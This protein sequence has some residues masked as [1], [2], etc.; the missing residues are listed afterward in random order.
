MD[1]NDI[2]RI[3]PN[4][5]LRH[6]IFNFDDTYNNFFEDS[7]KCI[8]YFSNI[9]A[10][11]S[12]IVFN[13]FS[14]WKQK[15]WRTIDPSNFSGS[16]NRLYNMMNRTYDPLK[17]NR[18]YIDNLMVNISID[19]L[20]D[21]A[22][23]QS[24]VEKIGVD[25]LFNFPIKNNLLT[26]YIYVLKRQRISSRYDSS[27]E[28][29]FSE[30]FNVLK[31][32][33]FITDFNTEVEFIQDDNFEDISW[34]KI[35][36]P[37]IIDNDV[38]LNYS[39]FIRRKNFFYLE[40]TDIE[41]PRTFE[42]DKEKEQIVCLNYLSFN[43]KYSYKILL[44]D[45]SEFKNPSFDKIIYGDTIVEEY[46]I[47]NDIVRPIPY[48]IDS[49]F[50]ENYIFLNNRFLR[51]FALV[52]ADTITAETKAAIQKKYGRKYSDVFEKMAVPSLYSGKTIYHYRWDEIILFLIIEQGSYELISF[53]LSY[54]RYSTFITSFKKRYGNNKVEKI[55]QSDIFIFKPKKL[56]QQN[57][58][59]EGNTIDCQTRA[60]LK[61][62]S[63]ILSS[64]TAQKEEY[65]Y[66][67]TI[68]DVLEDLR[69]V[70]KESTH[71]LDAL[72]YC[73]NTIIRIINFIR[74]YYVS[75]NY[76]A[77]QK[78]IFELFSIGTVSKKKYKSEYNKWYNEIKNIIENEKEK[79]RH[80]LFFT[81]N[82]NNSIE[83]VFDM[84]NAS[85]DKLIDFK[86]ELDIS[87]S[88]N[89]F[90]NNE[91]LYESTGKHSLFDEGVFL[92][93]KESIN[94]LKGKS[95][96]Q[97][98]IE[99]LYNK[100][101]NFLEYL[102]NGK[103]KGEYAE[104]AIY[105]LVGHYYNEINSRDG[106]KYAMFK[107]HDRVPFI[108]KVVSEESFNFN[109]SYYC[110]PNVN[111]V[112]LR[113]DKE[114]C[115]HIWLNPIVV[116]CEFFIP[117]IDWNISELKS[118]ADFEDAI[119]LIYNSDIELYK[120]LFG[121]IKNAKVIMSKMLEDECSKFYKSNYKILKNRSNKVIAIVAMYDSLT[122]HN[123]QWDEDVLKKYFSE[124]CIEFPE[125]FTETL[126]RLS[127]IFDNHQ[128]DGQYFIDDL[129]VSEE[130]RRQGIGKSLLMHLIR[131]AESQP[132]YSS[133]ILSVYSD[134]EIAINFYYS[135]GFIPYGIERD[136]VN[137]SEA[138]RM[139]RV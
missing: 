84:F 83:Y 47:N 44:T 64:D 30:F 123:I 34:I 82:K 1:A 53:I 39:A 20:L 94:A 32:F 4:E 107:I 124:N 62:A 129:C 109:C 97:A 78:K 11:S 137:H 125:K 37:S 45:N 8:G 130:Y 96:N 2:K 59:A 111:R 127:S 86:R 114:T 50:F 26:K 117:R 16:M 87:N 29:G 138:I 43:A 67:L 25:S 63:K 24:F 54:Q 79:D 91:A 72:N 35:K 41:D 15:Q 139:I 95:L 23:S 88:Q 120:N 133:I 31:M 33:P 7:K 12:I 75:I 106:Y 3:I 5:N 57:A 105:P 70:S 52:V 60:V 89:E 69:R 56:L 99:K 103:S 58:T 49:S 126:K 80:N 46:I 27:G 122:M 6:I 38:D 116:P 28:F 19:S 131:D 100:T 121:N 74:Y 110:I 9:M 134:N 13:V 40:K 48:S 77:V 68:D 73:L 104:I 71:Y 66:P 55:L 93:Y 22:E 98:D 136:D 61:L 42:I 90:R 128:T 102:K 112:V 18:E 132:D 108:A 81:S 101:Y 119:E 10:L 76:L 17:F 65:Y 92:S 36:I 85:I 21:D 115:E 51:D 113:E 118:S 14:S 135:L